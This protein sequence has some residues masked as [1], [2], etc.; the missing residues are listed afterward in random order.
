MSEKPIIKRSAKLNSITHSVRA[1]QTVLQYGVGAMVDFP[2][3]TLMTA[4]P[5]YWK[6]PEN[7]ADVVLHIH[8][9]RL[10]N[11]LNVDYFGVPKDK[12]EYRAG[13]AYVRF[14]QWYFC[15]KCRKFQT[16]EKWTTEF[17]RIQKNRE[18]DPDMKK[19]KCTECKV[20][21]VPARIITACEKGHINDFPWVLWT[22]EKS[23]GGRRDI[24]DNPELKFSTGATAS[25]GLEGLVVRC[26]CGAMTTLAGAFDNDA[27]KDINYYCNGFMPWKNQ[28]EACG[29]VP[30]VVQRGASKVYFPKVVS[31]LVIPPYSDKINYLIENSIKYNTCKE[32]IA[33]YDGEEKE[34]Y[35]QGKLDK[36]TLEISNEIHVE[37]SLVKNI[38]SRR[39]LNG[40]TNSIENTTNVRYRIEEYEALTGTIPEYGLDEFDFIRENMDI[41][42]YNI[43]GIIQVALV[44]KIREVRALT[45]FSRLNPPDSFNLNY[46]ESVNGLM[47]VKEPE[48]RW[49]P[50]YEVRG[51][52]IFLNF[53]DTEIERWIKEN[54][55]VVERINKLN[56][57]YSSTFMSKYSPREITPKFVF[58]HTMAHLLIRQL[59]FECGYTTASLRER[60]YC[61]SGN[62][63][64]KMNGIFIYTASGD[65]EGT[66][67]G[68][69][70][71][72]YSD[73]LPQTMIKAI[74][75]AQLCSN[76][77]V[78]IESV[79]QG[80]E[81]LN[82]AAC[83][84]CLLLPET[85]CEEF[86]VFLDRALIVGTL[87]NSDIGFYSQ[88]LTKIQT[89][90]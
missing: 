84:S 11:L 3:Q 17:I 39:L 19:P 54:K 50:G 76:D 90:L 49:Y 4:A 36:W 16:L 22:H 34:L 75:G 78:C 29:V 70:R 73:C 57:N 55:K 71:Q 37:S 33:D 68:L 38:L 9:E 58:L 72:G 1:A 63:N 40:G 62:E 69:V 67:G 65:S 52:G 82:L 7:A 26:K 6:D 8:D 5:E 24:C 2:D 28:R 64:F 43:P 79:G 30:Q 35:I 61:D 23:F 81:A 18:K 27:L 48:T 44:H 51:E 31:S 89:K 13:I 88:W 12:D 80:R 83:H 59:S 25:A 53:S 45:G 15:P 77:P 86:N 66:L 46:S 21:L 14:P 87:K 56:Q 60:I 41:E 85:S 10:E 20:E 42:S 74:T 32:I 47:S